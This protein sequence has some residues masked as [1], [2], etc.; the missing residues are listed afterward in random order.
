MA[1]KNKKRRRTADLKRQ[2]EQEK[3]ADEKSKKRWNPAGQ[4]LLWTDLVFLAATSLLETR[5]L[6]SELAGGLCAAIAVIALLIALWLL[7]GRKK[8]GGPRL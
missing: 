2:M 8:G 1:K 3:L 4:A 7:F 5:G 6:I